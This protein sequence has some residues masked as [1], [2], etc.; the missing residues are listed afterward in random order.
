MYIVC[1]DRHWQHVTKHQ[2]YG[3]VEFS[4]GANSD[5][6]ASGWNQ[7][8]VRPEHLYLNVVG[9]TM[10]VTIDPFDGGSISVKHYSVDGVQ[11]NEFKSKVK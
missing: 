9:G 2:D 11:L 8:D 5:D 4:I 1:G 7:E 10:T 6:H 3:I